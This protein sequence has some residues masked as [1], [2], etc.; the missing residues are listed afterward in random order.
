MTKY[1]DILRLKSLDFSERNI[2][3]SVPCSRNTVP[4][5]LKKTDE[6]DISWPLSDN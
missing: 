2:T 3:Q 1:R 6:K 5:V 4:K